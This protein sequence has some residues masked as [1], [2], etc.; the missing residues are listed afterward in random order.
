MKIKVNKINSKKSQTFA[1]QI[2]ASLLIAVVILLFTTSLIGSTNEQLVTAAQDSGCRAYLNS[3]NMAGQYIAPAQ[4]LLQEQR[5][6]NQLSLFC[7]TEFLLF[8]STNEEYVFSRLSQT[9]RRCNQR[10]GSGNLRFLD[11]TQ[12]SGSYCFV[13]AEI[14]FENIEAGDLTTYNYLEF[15]KWMEEEIPRDRN[16]QAKNSRELSNLIYVDIFG[17]DEER[18]LRE[19]RQQ[20]LE[21][22]NRPLVS[23]ES[24]TMLAAVIEKYDYLEN[25]YHRQLFARD[26]TY[27]VYRYNQGLPD[28][29]EL[30]AGLVAGRVAL[31]AT[32]FAP[33]IGRT[34]LGCGASLG[35]A[36]K[37]LVAVAIGSIAIDLINDQFMSSRIETLMTIFLLPGIQVQELNQNQM[38]LSELIQNRINNPTIEAAINDLSSIPSSY[39]DS[40]N[41]ENSIT[42]RNLQ[43]YREFLQQQ[44]ISLFS[45]HFEFATQARTRPELYYFT[46]RVNMDPHEFDY[47][48]LLNISSDIWYAATDEDA[49][50]ISIDNVREEFNDNELVLEILEELNNINRLN[51]RDLTTSRIIDESNLDLQISSDEIRNLFTQFLE[52]HSDTFDIEGYFNFEQYVEIM[53][54]EDFFRECGVVPNTD[55]RR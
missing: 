54:Q 52:I 5:L 23:F 13:C 29:T 42:L 49:E 44:E 3:F 27:V 41:N 36:C 22:I 40:L 20:R 14:E 32:R 18:K 55:L 21:L 24:K 19:A 6:W 1:L 7:K 25:I 38:L 12:R 43:L 8:E 16:E 48:L 9:A 15:G 33:V 53:P 45:R 39:Q 10:Y 46:P 26:R 4:R 17:G 2:L 50:L 47:I 34:V 28:N 11:F 30:T 35:I 37:A 51:F 31:G